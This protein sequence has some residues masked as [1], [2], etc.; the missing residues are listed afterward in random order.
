MV[1]F[2]TAIHAAGEE[3]Q[4]PAALFFI[5]GAV[6]GKDAGVFVEGQLPQQQVSLLLMTIFRSGGISAAKL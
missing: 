4:V 1:T 6:S 3:W 2:N 5:K